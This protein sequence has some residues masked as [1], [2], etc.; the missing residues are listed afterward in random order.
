MRQLVPMIIFLQILNIPRSFGSPL[1]ESYKDTTIKFGISGF[2]NISN[3]GL[4]PITGATFSSPV[5]TAGMPLHLNRFSYEPDFSIGTNGKPW[6]ASNHFRYH[7]QNIGK[8][9]FTI[10]VNPFFYFANLCGRSGKM[11]I[12]PQ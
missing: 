5:V 6:I 4:A 12:A 1:T 3:R 10:G 8:A 2:A 9:S 7:F 11:I